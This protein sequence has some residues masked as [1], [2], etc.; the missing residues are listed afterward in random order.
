MKSSLKQ[1]AETIVYELQL[2]PFLQSFGKADLVGS[3][4]LDLIVKP[5]IDLHLLLEKNDLI[6]VAQ[7]LV[8]F[9]I[10]KSQVSQ[11]RLTKY[12]GDSI[13]VAI[14]EYS[15]PTACWSFDIWLTTNPDKVA[16][17]KT[18]KLKKELTEKQ[19]KTIMQLKEYMHQQGRLRDGM[20]SIIYE[21]VITSD[22]K[23]PSQLE[24][25]LE[26]NKN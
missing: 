12:Y 7:K 21:A 17:E 24:K 1:E 16:F 9:L 2:L 26:N 23:T 8:G 25:F 3:V 6:P 20:S 4:V 22:V 15:G 11:V 5:D 18:E 13:N 19:R 14:D 10:E